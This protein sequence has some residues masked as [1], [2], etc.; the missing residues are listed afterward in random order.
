MKE[1]PDD[2]LV[3]DICTC[4]EGDDEDQKYC[5]GSFVCNTCRKKICCKKIDAAV[6]EGLSFCQA[7]QTAAAHPFDSLTGGFAGAGWYDQLNQEEFI[8]C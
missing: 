8:F 7:C 3:M 6:V 1:Q 2:V 4:G 5:G